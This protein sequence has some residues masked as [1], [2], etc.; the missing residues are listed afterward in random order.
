MPTITNTPPGATSPGSTRA[1]AARLSSFRA[2]GWVNE[3]T[4]LGGQLT[5]RAA[6]LAYETSPV[7][8]S[9]LIDRL[10]TTDW[11]AARIIEKMP[12][13]ALVRGFTIAG[14]EKSD[15]LIRD[16]ERLNT[17]ARF[18]GGAYQRAVYDGRAYGGAHL[19]LGYKL[20]DP[21]A[22]LTPEHEQGG[23][24]FLD[25][26][27][28]HEL[29]VLEREK[30]PSSPNV[31]MPT[32]Y[33]IEGSGGTRHPRFGQVFHASRSILFSGLPLR[34]AQGGG[35]S[36]LG[37]YPEVGVS[38]LAPVLGDIARYGTSWA[39]VSHLLQDANIGVMKIAGLVEALASED[40]AII[41]DRLATLQRTKALTRLMFLDADNNE[42]FSRV[43]VSFADIPGVMAQIILSISGAADM[44][45][46]ILFGTS[47]MGLN[48]NSAGMADLEQFYN[49]V[50]EYR[51][52]TIGPSLEKVLRAVSG[53]QDV[54]VK[55]PPLWQPTDNEA[56]QTRLTNANATQA[57]YNMNAVQPKDIVKAAKTGVHPETIGTVSDEREPDP[58]GEGGPDA[59]PQGGPGAR[60][61][62]A[63]GGTRSDATAADVKS[64]RVNLAS[65]L[66]TYEAN[67]EKLTALRD[68]AKVSEGDEKASLMKQVKAARR[69]VTKSEGALEE[70][71]ETLEDVHVARVEA[72]R[73][74]IVEHD[75]DDGEESAQSRLTR[76]KATKEVTEAEDDLKEVRE[77]QEK[78]GLRKIPGGYTSDPAEVKARALLEGPRGG[79]YYVSESGSKVYVE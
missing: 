50:D 53:G 19:F 46:K 20:G 24:L 64:A 35:A 34:C 11:L 30:D 17:T 38:V 23:L 9:M 26:V 43:A 31:G 65:A 67:A 16:F 79:R 1:L 36:E 2:D 59:P 3:A 47:P 70:S 14:Q 55:F 39:A 6:T 42:D 54:R 61:A 13:I 27:R 29:R 76:F 71:I 62:A 25:V 56:A 21:T 75:P 5:D 48:A 15:D 49:S 69:A 77:I 10:Y 58:A 63:L 73:D 33:K 66:S 28:Q 72:A 12:S 7:P 41:K 44:P 60:L 18:P 8:S 57:Y 51:R 52:R 40:D 45:A 37:D 68:K 78:T 4:G 32:L 22:L 74:A